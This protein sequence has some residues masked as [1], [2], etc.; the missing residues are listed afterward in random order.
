M[1]EEFKAKRVGTLT[2][3]FRNDDGYETTKAGAVIT[4]KFAGNYRIIFEL[5]TGGKT[6][7][8]YDEMEPVVAIKTASMKKGLDI[9]EAFFH[10]NA[11]EDMPKRPPRQD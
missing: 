11:W 9:S 2:L 3:K 10:L 5:P 8:G 1:S 7:N 6:E 4:T